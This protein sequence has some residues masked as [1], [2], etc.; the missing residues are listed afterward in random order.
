MNSATNYV[1][2]LYD[3]LTFI[4]LYGG[5]VFVVVFVTAF[6]LLFWFYFKARQST[7]EIAADWTAQRCKPQNML[8]A[9][10][11]MEPT[12]MTAAE[13]TRNNF[14]YCVQHIVTDASSY[15]LQPLNYLMQAVGTMQGELSASMDDSRGF[16]ANLRSSVTDVTESIFQRTLSVMIPVQ[17]MFIAL[18]DMLGKTQGIMTASLYTFLGSYFTLQS[19]MGAILEAIVKILITL[20]VLI[21]GLWVVPVTWPAAGAAT[22][23]YLSIAIP[24]AI[25]IAF[26]TEVLHI[27]T[28]GIPKLRCFDGSTRMLLHGGA[29]RTIRD[30]QAGDVLCDGSTVTSTVM[31][32]SEMLPMYRVGDTI[33]SGNHKVLDLCSNA[34]CRVDT[35]VHARRMPRSYAA[36]NRFVYCLNTSTKVIRLPRLTLADWDE[37][38]GSTLEGALRRLRLPSATALN[39]RLVEAVP[40]YAADDTVTLAGG[41][42]VAIKDACVGDLLVHGGCVYGIVRGL[43]G[44]CSLLTTGGTFVRNGVMAHDYNGEV[45]AIVK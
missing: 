6:V 38:V 4:D 37:V 13:Y 2:G 35:L 24:T 36:D 23:V 41:R 26:M 7:K 9:G 22:A 15:A 25:I 34:W 42:V 12:D 21:V 8:L 1:S 14:D 5:S 40:L 44:R 43:E 32:T 18:L 17:R 28:S 29:E 11:I 20:T 10:Q 16:L 33:V 27:K 39:E 19:L 3:R 31:V 45:D 30:L